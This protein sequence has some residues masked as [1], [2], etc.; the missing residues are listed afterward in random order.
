MGG[1]PPPSWLPHST[2][3]GATIHLVGCHTPP[4]W[5]PRS[6]KVGATIHLVGCH[7]PPRETRH[8]TLPLHPGGRRPGLLLG[9]AE[10]SLDMAFQ[11]CLDG[12]VGGQTAWPRL[13]TAVAPQGP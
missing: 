4:R 10:E 12:P 1:P 6:T 7:T 9:L 13:A 11:G 8:A 3:V 2:K 5:G